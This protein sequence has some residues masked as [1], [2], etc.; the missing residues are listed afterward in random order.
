MEETGRHDHSDVVIYA[1]KDGIGR[2]ALTSSMYEAK[3]SQPS[4]YSNLAYRRTQKA[5]ERLPVC[6]S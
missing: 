3:P 4:G 5:K 6:C 1:L 2:E